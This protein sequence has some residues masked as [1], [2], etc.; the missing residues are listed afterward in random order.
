MSPQLELNP[1]LTDLQADTPTTEPNWPRWSMGIFKW[2]DLLFDAHQQMLTHLIRVQKKTKIKGI[3]FWT[4]LMLHLRRTTE[5]PPCLCPA[6]T[7]L[8]CTLL[9]GHVTCSIIVSTASHVSSG[10]L[11]ALDVLPSPANT[12][13]PTA[14]SSSPAPCLYIVDAQ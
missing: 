12:L 10:P 1:Q 6:P 4:A 13:P 11:P 5:H 8:P 9:P 7:P 3:N 14:V 2:K